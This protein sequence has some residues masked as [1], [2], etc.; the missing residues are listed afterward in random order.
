MKGNACL[1]FP[2]ST[3]QHVTIGSHECQWIP[4]PFPDRIWEN[5]STDEVCLGTRVNKGLYFFVMPTHRNF[6][7]HH[8]LQ[9][10]TPMLQFSNSKRPPGQMVPRSNSNF[11]CRTYFLSGH[12]LLWWAN[13][14]PLTLQS[15]R[16]NLWKSRKPC[17]IMDNIFRNLDDLFVPVWG[18]LPIPIGNCKF[19]SKT[20]MRGGLQIGTFSITHHISPGCDVLAAPKPCRFLIAPC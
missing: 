19:V 3:T 18:A 13:C 16:N 7:F 17:E 12:T 5:I 2:L 1:D 20:T 11:S 9:C 15:V 10:S 8:Q 4:C 6:H 14:R